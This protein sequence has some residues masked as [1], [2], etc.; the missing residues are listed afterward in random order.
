M[1]RDAL[2]VDLMRD[3]GCRL[4][5]Y[6]DT[7]GK[8][9]IGIGRNLT[10]NGITLPEA[11]MLALNDIDAIELE[12]A[13]RLP[14]FASAQEPVQ[15]GLAN[16]GFNLGWPRLAGFQKMLTALE[17]GQYDM[18]ADE[19]LASKWAAQVGDR[20]G[21]IATLFRSAPA[22]EPPSYWSAAPRAAAAEPPGAG[23]AP[24]RKG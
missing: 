2:L 11:K 20:A 16:M 4:K 7:V 18:A 19:A 14:W 12:L 8:L 10:D 17:A 1:N 6:V 5:P 9:T 23:R 22:A 24:S 13:M 15:R 3:E 21:R